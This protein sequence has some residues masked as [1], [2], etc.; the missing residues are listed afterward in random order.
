MAKN[1]KPRAS[2]PV[3]AKDVEAKKVEYLWRD[4][5]PMGMISVIA[6]RPDQGKGLFAAHVAADVSRRGGNVLYSAVEDDHGLMTRPRLE[7]AGAD[8][9]HILLWRFGLPT[10]MAELSARVIE[11]NI[12]LV[13][14]DPFSAH[15]I[16]VSKHSDNAR[17]VTNPLSELA[18]DTG[19][20]FL[21]V[22]HVIKKVAKGAPPLSGIGGVALPQAARAAFLYGVDPD[23][24]ERRLLCPAKFNIGPR[25]KALSFETDTEELGLVGEVPYLVVQG[26]TEFDGSRLL[27]GKDSEPGKV[28]RKPD[29]RRQAG[30]WL[31]QYLVNAGQPVRSA[32]VLEDGKQYGLTTKTIRN[33]AA[34]LGIVKNPPGGGPKVTWDLPQHIKKAVGA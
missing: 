10:Q 14:M 15:L 27:S 3:I 30:E 26:E 8:L 19:C 11:L 13:V 4:R 6:G 33:A 21:V 31:V 32:T 24:S 12:D 20:A 1:P 16:G 28:G 23:D 2:D 18:E 17:Q 7:A 25:P 5:V 34:D 9:S 22:D 29:K